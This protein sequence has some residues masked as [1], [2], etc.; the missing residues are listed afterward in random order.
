MTSRTTH[1]LMRIAAAGGGFAID[2]GRFTTEDLM[3]V[4]AASGNKG[5]TLHLHGL[6]GRT[7]EELMRIAAAGDGAVFFDGI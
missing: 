7:S 5:V 4:A 6:S 3:R 2:G 1:D